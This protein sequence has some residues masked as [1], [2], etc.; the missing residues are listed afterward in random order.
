MKFPFS[1]I[2][3]QIIIL[4][5]TWAFVPHAVEAGQSGTEKGS[6]NL[7]LFTPR[8][9]GDPFWGR[10]VEHAK[11]AA[12]DLGGTVRLYYAHGNRE[13]MRRQIR[14]EASSSSH[15]DVLVFPNFKKGG[16]SFLKIIETHG[17]PAFLVNSGFTDEEEVDGPR[18]SFKHWLGELLPAEREA[19]A[20]LAQSLIEEGKKRFGASPEKPLE[21]IGITGIVSDYASIER[22]E[23]LKNMVE[24][25]PE[26]LLRQIIPANWLAGDARTGF[27]ILKKRYP[28]LS[29]VW[30]ASDVMAKGVQEGA[31]ALNIDLRKDLVIGGVDWAETGIASV[32]EG[33]QYASAGGHFLEGGWAVVMVHDFLNGRD[34]ADLGL[35]WRSRMGLITTAGWHQ[36]A[37]ALKKIRPEQIDYRKYSRVLNPQHMSYDFSLESL[38]SGDYAASGNQEL[39]GIIPEETAD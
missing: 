30:T 7:A 16:K 21:M 12:R 11:K 36:M 13:R 22:T 38:L 27:T 8:K 2:A 37:T 32:R 17:V 14:K 9:V 31:V 15:A 28:S 29:V 4:A 26:V 5:C 24:R 3:V 19:G 6:W 1:K 35:R 33:R 10:F 20:L 18:K 25:Y 34:F 23:G 39:P